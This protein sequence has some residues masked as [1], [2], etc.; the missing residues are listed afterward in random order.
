MLLLP[1]CVYA[2]RQTEY[3]RKG[4][5]AMGRKDYRDARMWY[6]EGVTYCD[7]YSIGQLTKIWQAD[8]TMR[9][10]MR[11]A[12]GK[13]L[14]CLNELATENDT[15]AMK[16]LIVYYEE[17]IGVSPN[18]SSVNYWRN[19]LEQM[20]QPYRETVY[21]SEKERMKFFIGYHFSPLAPF[22]IQIGGF[23]TKLGWYVRVRSDFSLQG[24]TAGSLENGKLELNDNDIQFARYNYDSKPNGVFV[25]S[26]GMMFKAIPQ[27]YVSAGVGYWKCD[28]LRKYVSL[29]DEGK[30]L[31][32]FWV[33]IP[34]RYK[35]AVVDLDAVSFFG[36]RFYGTAGITVLS[37]SG[38]NF[39]Y[40]YPNIGL[41]VYF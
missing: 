22:G 39:K 15:V 24:N 30:P 12:M 23:N 32:D 14:N 27:L 36:E 1:L 7:M 13:S 11:T 8:E 41:G 37:Q 25:G 29:D 3:N 28:L 20:R 38:L 33:N 18:E 4:D 31:S 35:G 5:E 21:R 9:V 17:G 34:G 10:S 19:Q 6:E 16:Q 26:V 2:Q 40:V